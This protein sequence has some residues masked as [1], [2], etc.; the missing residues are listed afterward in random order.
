MFAASRV[1]IDTT[2]PVRTVILEITLM[3]ITMT[4]VIL[5]SMHACTREREMNERQDMFNSIVY[6]TV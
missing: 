1:L 5:C 3:M 2:L 4:S 6:S